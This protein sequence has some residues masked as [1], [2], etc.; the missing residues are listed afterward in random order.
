MKAIERLSR[1]DPMRNVLTLGAIAPLLI[2]ASPAAQHYH[3]Y[4]A[5]ND[6]KPRPWAILFP[7]AMG[8]GTLAPGNQYVEMARFLNARGID[9]MVI[10]DDRALAILKPKGGAGPARAALATDALAHAREQGRMDMRCPGI[11]MGW[12][13]GG[14]GALTLASGAEGGK[15]GIKAAIVYYPSVRGQPKPWPQLHPVLALQGTSD[16][17]APHNNLEALAAARSPQMAFTIKLYPNARHRFDVARPTDKPDAA[18]IEKDF[19]DAAHKDALAAID[20]FL[21]DQGISGQSCAL[22]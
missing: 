21:R 3:W 16:S 15:T 20:A 18:A 9:A 22:D 12:S 1:R 11:A 5:A 14:E 19:D 10:D 6:A 8:I 13:R 17:L 4:P 2:A 7:R